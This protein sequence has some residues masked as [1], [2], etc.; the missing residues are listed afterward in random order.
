MGGI[1]AAIAVVPKEVGVGLGILV[2]VGVVIGLV[3]WTSGELGKERAATVQREIPASVMRGNG[4]KERQHRRELIGPRYAERFNV[5]LKAVEQISTTEAARDGWLGEIDFS[6][7]LRCT[8]DDLQRAIALRRTAKKLSELA[9]PSESDRQIL[10]DAKAAASKIDRIAFDRIDLIKKCA[11]EARRIDESLAR[12]RESARTA[13]ERAQ[14]NGQLHGMLYGIAKA[15][16]VSPADSGAERVMSRVAAYQ[17]I[18]TLI[19]QG[20]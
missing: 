8:F 12:E 20:A 4:D 3:V 13:D 17:E 15:P 5:A 18:K 9:E 7:D 11:S 14:L 2:V 6:A 19:E 10:K 16:S 1:A